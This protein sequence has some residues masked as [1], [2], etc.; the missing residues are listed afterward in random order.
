MEVQK[1]ALYDIHKQLG[2]KMVEFAGFYMPIQYK[3]I[4]EE[5]S[6]VRTSVGIF[7]VSHIRLCVTIMAALLMIY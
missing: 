7:D 4:N 5:H 2:A 6:R 1:T 3:G